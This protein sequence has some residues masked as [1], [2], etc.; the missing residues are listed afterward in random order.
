MMHALF[1]N[2]ILEVVPQTFNGSLGEKYDALY[3]GDFRHK[4]STK[5]PEHW[6]LLDVYPISGRAQ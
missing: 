5:E 1:G 2:H 4:G 3:V 6:F